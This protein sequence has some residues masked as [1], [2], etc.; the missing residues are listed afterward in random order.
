MALTAPAFCLGPHLGPH[1]GLEGQKAKD[2]QREGEAGNGDGVEMGWSRGW[3]GL[4]TPGSTE[5]GERGQQE[6]AC[7]A[8]TPGDPA[9]DPVRR[10]LLS[11]PGVSNLGKRSHSATQRPVAGNSSQGSLW[12]Q[13]IEGAEWI[14]LGKPGGK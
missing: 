11:L 1:F 9:P 7:L 6:R 12:P 2:R 4:E 10:L 14:L 8:G 5:M 13:K 3:N